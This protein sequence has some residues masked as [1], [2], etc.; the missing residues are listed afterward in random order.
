MTWTQ[1]RIETLT[2]LWADGLSASLIARKMGFKS[3][4]A[5]LGKVNRL[6]LPSRKT[7]EGKAYSRVRTKRAPNMREA[8][9]RAHLRLVT[10][11]TP[12]DTPEPETLTSGDY[13]PSHATGIPAAV[14]SLHPDQCRFPI[15]ETNEPGFHFC[16]R[17]KTPGSSY[18]LHHKNIC[19]SGYYKPSKRAGRSPVEFA[20]RA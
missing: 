9:R 2:R 18:C 5:I 19:I 6:G 7:V 13:A 16:D 14:A 20:R 10:P 17:I 12:P 8:D 15:G 1:D 11:D 3:R 4:S